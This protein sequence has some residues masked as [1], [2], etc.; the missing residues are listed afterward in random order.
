MLPKRRLTPDQVPPGSTVVVWNFAHNIV[1]SEVVKIL[2]TLNCKFREQCT[3][4][5]AVHIL[6]HQHLQGFRRRTGQVYATYASPE[7]AELA[8]NALNLLQ[9]M[10]HKLRVCIA[11]HRIEFR[12]AIGG[13]VQ[14][15]E[16][17]YGDDIFN[18]PTWC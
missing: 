12:N 8:V 18:C 3:A 14:V 11:D 15:G 13:Q 7:L 6:Y 9:V 5:V 10:N 4:L 17:R 2:N 1:E 16:P